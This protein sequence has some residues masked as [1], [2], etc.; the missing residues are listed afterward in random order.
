MSESIGKEIKY[1]V[2]VGPQVQDVLFSLQGETAPPVPAG[3]DEYKEAVKLLDDY[4]LPMKCLPLEQH[5]FRN[6]EQAE[7]EPIERFVLRLRE[8]GILCEYG[9]HLDE[10]IKEQLFEKAGRSLETIGKH[11]QSIKISPCLEEVNKIARTT[12]ASKN[13]ANRECYRCERSGHYANDENC[14]ALNRKCERCG[15]V[16]HFKKRCNTKRKNKVGEKLQRRVRV[17]QKVEDSDD[18]N[19]LEE[20]SEDSDSDRVQYLFATDPDCV[21]K[22]VCAVGGVKTTWVVDS[23]A[24]VNVI[25]R[26]TWEHLKQQ[27]VRVIHQTT[28]VNKSLKAYGGFPINVA[29]M[30]SAEVATMESVTEADIVVETGSCCLLGRKTAKALGILNINTAVWE[31]N[32]ER[33]VNSVL[34]IKNVAY[35]PETTKRLLSAIKAGGVPAM[36]LKAE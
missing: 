28:G 24:G 3:S 10:E 13:K 19:D 22:V 30:F 26:Q 27:K 6:L 1:N 2:D 31:V 29:G 11:R 5:K 12:S 4:F 7:D 8:Q 14:P 34:K 35:T 36:K 18:S 17:N 15:F 25:N 33:C 16:G 32:D 23:G 21:E 20:D 9:D